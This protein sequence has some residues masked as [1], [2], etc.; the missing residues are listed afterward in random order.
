MK[1]EPPVDLV[2][3]ALVE[4]AELRERLDALAIETGEYEQV[5]TTLDER[6]RNNRAEI[7]RLTQRIAHLRQ[8]R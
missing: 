7:V 8:R 1:P 3:E 4:I 6:V 2:D 5:I